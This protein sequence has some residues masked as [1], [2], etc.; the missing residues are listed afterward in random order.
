MKPHKVR[1]GVFRLC[2]Y[3]FKF[4]TLSRTSVTC[5]RSCAGRL[6]VQNRKKV[7]V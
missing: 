6:A 7:I 4:P 1:S 5:S 2:L 3:C